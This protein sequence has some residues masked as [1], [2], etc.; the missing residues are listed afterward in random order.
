MET[1]KYI[2]PA[3]RNKSESDDQQQQQQ[4]QHANPSSTTYRLKDIEEYF[5]HSCQYNFRDKFRNI[6]S[7]C[8]N[9]WFSEGGEPPS[10]AP[11]PATTTRPLPERERERG[12]GTLNTAA[13]EPDVLAYIVLFNDAHPFWGTKREILCKSNLELLPKSFAVPYASTTTTDN[14]NNNN[15]NNN[16]PTPSSTY[17]ASYPIFIHKLAPGQRHSHYS[18]SFAG[19]YRIRAVRYLEPRSRELAAY[20]EVKFGTQQRSAR[21]WV[22]SFWRRWA[23]I[24]MDL[25]AGREGDQGWEGVADMIYSDGDGE[26]E[27]EGEGER[28]R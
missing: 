26:G 28:E 23:V 5:G 6:N 24:T 11:V 18:Y 1:G 2:P 19:Y 25:D 22:E 27:G 4:Q 8:S 7:S 13:N 14:N 17:T 16:N 3:L 10:P 20:L 9:K 21:R 15:N 12:R